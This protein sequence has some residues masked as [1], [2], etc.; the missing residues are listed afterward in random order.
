MLPSEVLMTQ[1]NRSQRSLRRISL[2]MVHNS[3]TSEYEAKIF[4]TDSQRKIINRRDLALV[5]LKRRSS[6]EVGLVAYQSRYC[7]RPHTTGYHSNIHR[8]D[9]PQFWIFRL[10]H[11]S[12]SWQPP[13]WYLTYNSKHMSQ[14]L[15][16]Y[17]SLSIQHG[18]LH[19][20]SLT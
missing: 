8:N 12:D 4:T 18:A 1:Y 15:Y 17:I 3:H 10:Q 14:L 5:T 19:T 16:H 11:P 9:I 13:L 20:L 7:H 6:A 2:D